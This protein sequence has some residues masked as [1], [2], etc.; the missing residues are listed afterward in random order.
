MVCGCA[1]R[2]LDWDPRSASERFQWGDFPPEVQKCD[3]QDRLRPMHDE[4]RSGQFVIS[5]R[6][7]RST[8]KSC[9]CVNAVNSCCDVHPMAQASLGAYCRAGA[10]M[11][12]GH[13]CRLLMLWSFV[14]WSCVDAL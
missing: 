13:L 7:S 1:D 8:V 12:A 10:R 4:D 14:L 9:I 5:G 11:K 2:V 3:P 6:A